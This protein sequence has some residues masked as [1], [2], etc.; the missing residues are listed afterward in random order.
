MLPDIACIPFYLT[1]T[2]NSLMQK[3]TSVQTHIYIPLSI[4][5]ERRRE[6]GWRDEVTGKGKEMRGGH[7]TKQRRKRNFFRI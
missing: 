7:I 4:A 1:Y 3:H 2:N 6:G 5:K